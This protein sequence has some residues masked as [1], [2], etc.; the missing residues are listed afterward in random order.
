MVEMLGESWIY[1][2][3]VDELRNLWRNEAHFSRN[4][5]DKASFQQAGLYDKWYQALEDAEDDLAEAKLK[6]GRVRSK[7]ELGIRNKYPNYKEGAIKAKVNINKKVIKAEGVVRKYEK[8]VRA[9][10]GAVAM[11]NMRKSMIQTLKDLYISNYWSK[12]SPSGTPLYE[13]RNTK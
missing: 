13:R 8:Y 12:T 10:K 6:E 7:A 9:L 5:L 3:T 1:D 11:F 2:H 4:K